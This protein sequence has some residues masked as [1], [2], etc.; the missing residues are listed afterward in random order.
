[1]KRKRDLIQEKTDGDPKEEENESVI[2][3][4]APYIQDSFG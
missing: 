1:M 4:Q 3:S 2:T